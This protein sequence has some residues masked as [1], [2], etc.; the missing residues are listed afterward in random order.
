MKAVQISLFTFFVFLIPQTTHCAACPDDDFVFSE[1]ACTRPQ[2]I[3]DA[4]VDNNPIN[5]RTQTPLEIAKLTLGNVASLAMQAPLEKAIWTLSNYGNPKGSNQV[6]G[7]KKDY[8]SK[9]RWDAI[10]EGVTK[11]AD[12]ELF[13]KHIDEIPASDSHKKKIRS[14]ADSFRKSEFERA[15]TRLEYELQTAST[16]WSKYLQEEEVHRQMLLQHYK[17]YKQAEAKMAGK[18]SPL[19]LDESA[20]PFNESIFLPENFKKTIRLARDK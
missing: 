3:F 20:L 17:R 10:I 7:I 18:T 8:G 4:T 16:R 6:V 9:A 14:M 1:G 19:P 12:V 11:P 5:L 15:E 13:D 2:E